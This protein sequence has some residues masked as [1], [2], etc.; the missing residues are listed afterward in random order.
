M[1]LPLLAAETPREKRRNLTRVSRL[2]LKI[3]ARLW[4]TVTMQCRRQ[5]TRVRFV[6]M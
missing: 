4:C 6:S 5:I 3:M 1:L 2:V